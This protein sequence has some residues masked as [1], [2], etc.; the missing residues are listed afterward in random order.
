MADAGQRHGDAPGGGLLH[1]LHGRDC[2]SGQEYSSARPVAVGSTGFLVVYMAWCGDC[3][4][5]AWEVVD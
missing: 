3:G 2:A 5:C 1:G 4:A